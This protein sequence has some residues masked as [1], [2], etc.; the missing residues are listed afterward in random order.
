M[1]KDNK[2]Y[3]LQRLRGATRTWE[4]VD[5]DDGVLAGLVV[6]NDVNSEQRNAE[7]LS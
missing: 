4:C 2:Y 7:G 6:D 1:H 5:I 3:P